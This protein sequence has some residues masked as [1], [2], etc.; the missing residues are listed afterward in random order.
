MILSARH[1]TARHGT[2]R[3]GT[4]RHGTARHG[5]ARHGTARHGTA[6]HGTARGT[7][8]CFHTHSGRPAHYES[9]RAAARCVP[10]RS[11]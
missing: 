4:A 7:G 3:H 11:T 10:S 5:T 8:E 2:A 9:K 6:R 1:G